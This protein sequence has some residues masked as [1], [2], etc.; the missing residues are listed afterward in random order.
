MKIY[1]IQSDDSKHFKQYM[2]VSF[3]DANIVEEVSGSTP[4]ASISF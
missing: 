3:I 1:Y 2:L 4:Q